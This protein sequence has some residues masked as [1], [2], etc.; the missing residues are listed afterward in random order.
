MTRLENIIKEVDTMK[1]IA[2]DAVYEGSTTTHE[3]QCG[4]CHFIR[5]FMDV[6]LI[7]C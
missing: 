3:Y 6:G 5:R 2:C 4:R 1:E 7:M